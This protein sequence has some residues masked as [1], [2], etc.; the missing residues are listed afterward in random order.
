MFDQRSISLTF[1]MAGLVICLINFISTFIQKRTAKPQNKLFLVLNT[2]VAVNCISNMISHVLSAGKT[3]SPTGAVVLGILPYIYFLI[4]N[5]LCPMFFCY[6]CVVSGSSGVRKFLNNKVYAGLIGISEL[7]VVINPVTRCSW[8]FDEHN[9][10]TRNWGASVFY[11]TAGVFFVL[12]VSRL[13]FAWDTLSVSRKFSLGFFCMIVIAGVILQLVFPLIQTELFA[14]A[15]GLAGLM[16]E[17]ENEDDRINPDSG[18][19]NR[20]AMRTDINGYIINRR[21]LHIIGIRITNS[22]VIEKFTGAENDDILSSLISDFLLSIAPYYHIYDVNSNTYAITLFGN[23]EKEI[24]EITSYISKR[25]ESVWE[26]GDS[27]IFLSAVIMAA[28]IPGRLSSAADVFYMLDCPVSPGNK[29][30]VLSGK[31]LDY[32]VR[33]S[34]VENAVSRGLGD[35]SFAV[36]YQPT[37]DI[38]HNVIHGAEALLRMYD[39]EI[40]K[41]PPD[42]FV[43]VAEQMGLIDD[44]DDFVLKEVCT[45]IRSGVPFKAGINSINVNLSVVQCMKPDF[46]EHI[47]DLVN[48]TGIDKHAINFEVTESVATNDY[49][50]LANVVR[51]LKEKGFCFSMD[52]YGT[53][54]SNINSIFSID[55][56]VVKIDKSILWGAEKSEMG[57]II[58]ENSIRMISSMGK[59]IL[60]EGVETAEQVKMLRELD[61]DYIQG[62]YYS[63]PL[64]KERFVE[65][66]RD[67]KPLPGQENAV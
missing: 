65:F 26:W 17:I 34:S 1:C 9:N 41:V 51:A 47:I 54:Y 53:G 33:R 16:Y 25:F 59:K 12:A 14:E 66:I 27:E 61:V 36:H 60:V 37:Y 63:K 58:L 39:K 57:R 18:F 56:D 46:V 3:L 44:I 35:H 49:D 62:Y 45:F 24:A 13:V 21:Q 19:C 31:D 10:Y 22:D 32:L 11:I 52:D 48:E 29:K 40:G 23:K 5:L 6:V 20:S 55:F 7:F 67:S 64:S 15:V 30:K 28:D 43:P 42:E 38:K 4:H 2:I 50:T 8:Y